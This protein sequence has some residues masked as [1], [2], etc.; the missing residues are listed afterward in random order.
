M[1]KRYVL[2]LLL[3][4][5][6][7]AA[8]GQA[9]PDTT[10]Y[11]AP[12]VSAYPLLR[13]CQTDVHPGWTLDSV[14]RCGESGLLRMFAQNLRY[15]E[16]A[17]QAN[18]QGTVVL[19][20]IVETNGRITN[21]NTLKDI[22]GGCGMEAQRLMRALDTLGLR[23]MPAQNGVTA[24]RSRLVLPLRFKL[25]EALPYYLHPNG[26]TIYNVIDRQPEFKQ[27]LDSL[28]KMLVNRL[29]Y[30]KAYRD[31]CKAGVMELSLI[32]RPNGSVEVD[33]VL[34]FSNLG[35]DFQ[36]EALRLAKRTAGMWAPATYNN[37][38][39]TATLPLRMVF[40]SPAN[41]C[42]LANDQFDRTMILAD[43]GA[44]LLEAGETDQ[45]LAKWTEALALF[46]NNTEILYYRGT[47]LLNNDKRDE[48][49]ADYNR[50]KSILGTTWFEGIR[51]VVCGW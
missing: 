32:V 40:K 7:W 5:N 51:R 49:C 31:S 3:G 25:Q 13:N 46:P 26:D 33:N 20:M 11:D 28:L 4:L 38:P 2:L 10:I 22:G 16:A 42:S 45:A 43:E 23:F 36:F 44:I 48:A 12:D 17:R 27:G 29:E 8:S 14:R 18:L 1:L 37:L 6:G 34:D 35:F 19:Q 30:P 21:I 15:P 47:T 9:T 41:T 50:I 39:V 24:V